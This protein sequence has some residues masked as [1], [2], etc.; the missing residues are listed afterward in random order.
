MLTFEDDF[1][2]PG[3]QRPMPE[4]MDAIDA[5]TSVAVYGGILSREPVHDL[6]AE[7]QAL[8]NGFHRVRAE[9]KRVING[10][11]DVNQLVPLKYK[12]AGKKSPPACPNPGMPQKT[13]MQREIELW[14]TPNGL[15][16]D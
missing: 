2:T 1:V 9:D 8:S 16:D 14:K 3:A 6:D 13:N 4:S 12:G 15:T 10:Q 5:Q 7:A 11:S